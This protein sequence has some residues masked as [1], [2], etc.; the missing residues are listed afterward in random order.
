MIRK[1][2][3]K[4]LVSVLKI[5]KELFLED[6]WTEEMFRSEMNDNPFANVYVYELNGEIIGYFD[7]LISYENAELANIGVL[8]QFQHNGIGS[9]MMEYIN[10]LVQKNHCENFT[11][12]VRMSNENAIQLYEKFGFKIVSSR[13]NY[14]A[15]G[16]D[17]YLMYKV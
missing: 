13:K 7:L 14:Y 5:E 3:N 1:I 8:R 2:E 15:D 6:S 4:D 12:E 11:L 9:Q 17:A 16:E 10:Q